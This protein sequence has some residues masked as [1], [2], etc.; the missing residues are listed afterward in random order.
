MKSPFWLACVFSI[1]TLSSLCASSPD[2][3]KAF[4]DGFKTAF[5]A[6]DK[7]A[8]VSF[9]YTKGA[10]PMALEFYTMMITEGAGTK[11]SAIELLELTSD[12]KK[13]AGKPQEGPDGESAKLPLP[14][15]RRL[16]MKTT[17]AGG[18]STSKF[19]VAESGGKLVI[20]VPSPVK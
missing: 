14:P 1:M 2:Q 8:L 6:G 13:E 3:E 16:V 4:L 7:K 15:T 11:I 12:E 17:T 10:D 9:L 5:E 18:T 19:F 20:P